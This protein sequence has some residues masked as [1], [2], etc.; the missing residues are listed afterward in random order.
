[1]QLDYVGYHGRLLE[2]L[3]LRPARGY[4]NKD[5][6]FKK[7]NCALT[8]GQLAPTVQ[9]AGQTALILDASRWIFQPKREWIWTYH[10]PREL[11]S[12]LV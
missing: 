5:K 6:K 10:T 3:F 8:V 2:Y 12:S 4:I 9:K 11:Y 7:K 1:M